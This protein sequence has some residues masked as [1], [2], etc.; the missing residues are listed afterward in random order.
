MSPLFT[1]PLYA[2]SLKT[3][4]AP[5]G[6]IIK[7]GTATFRSNFDSGSLGAVELIGTN[8]YRITL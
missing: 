4:P 7:I 1:E 3:S 2:P 8:S 5:H 6:K